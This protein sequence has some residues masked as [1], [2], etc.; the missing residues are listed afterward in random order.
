VLERAYKLFPACAG[1]T[2]TPFKNF[3]RNSSNAQLM[4]ELITLCYDELSFV[5][6]A[7]LLL[8]K[9]NISVSTRT[10]AER[11]KNW[12]MAKTEEVDES[13]LLNL[14]DQISGDNHH[15]LGYRAVRHI[16]RHR[17]GV[18]VSQAAVR[19]AMKVAFPNEVAERSKGVLRRREYDG[20]DILPASSDR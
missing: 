19:L 3:M 6:L 16:I 10:L 9:F 2:P 15:V 8:D 1:D 13:L 18:R 17:Y 7:Q 14:I 4:R 12:G 5:D 20:T 11:C